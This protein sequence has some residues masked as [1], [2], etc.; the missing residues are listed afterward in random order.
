MLMSLISL[1]FVLILSLIFVVLVLLVS[2]IIHI[3]YLIFV[4]R[5]ISD[6]VR[7]L[8]EQKQK[9]SVIPDLFSSRAEAQ[10]VKFSFFL[11]GLDLNYY[12]VGKTY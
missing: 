4:R 10:R 9:A 11:S 3:Q 7:A 8:D 6:V 1:I 12:V 2:N 5:S